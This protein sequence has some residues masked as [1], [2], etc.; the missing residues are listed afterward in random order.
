MRIAIP[1]VLLVAGL[2]A[3]AIAQPPSELAQQRNAALPQA[4][5]LTRIADEL[6]TIRGYIVDST[7]ARVERARENAQPPCDF[8]FTVE[9]ARTSVGRTIIYGDKDGS[10]VYLTLP[11]VADQQ[12][13]PGSLF[14][15]VG[16]V[17]GVAGGAEGNGTDTITIYVDDKGKSSLYAD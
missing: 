7:S 8:V 13:K 9:R 16:R 6:T 5:S 1:V 11:Y 15:A 4:V 12:I 2:L 14:R 3:V 17:T 10:G